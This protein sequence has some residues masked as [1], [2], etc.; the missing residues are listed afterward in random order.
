MTITLVG[1]DP[2][3]L[4]LENDPSPSLG[5]PGRTRSSATIDAMP[6]DPSPP[7]PARVGPPDPARVRPPDPGRARRPVPLLT[8]LLAPLLDS[9]TYLRYVHLL[10][11][12]VLLLPY[13]AL[14]WLLATSARGAGMDPVALVL[15]LVPA[16]GGGIAVTLI[17]GVRA[18]EVAA[19]RALLGVQLPDPDPATA[20]WWPVRRRSLGYLAVAMLLGGLA[21]LAT[22]VAVP[23]SVGFLL[24]PWRTVTLLI[25]VF[26][27]TRWSPGSA[28]PRTDG[29]ARKFVVAVSCARP[30]PWSPA[31]RL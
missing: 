25:A 16:V 15:L 9:T 21:A 4:P 31:A 26:R 30:L 13:L 29:C 7:D 10:L 14:G 28:S 11:G 2:G 6:A 20:A 17:P 27:A 8:L 23:S 12:A 18:L 24:A 5:G 22:L 1:R 19:A 3:D